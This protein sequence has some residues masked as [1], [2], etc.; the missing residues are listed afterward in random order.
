MNFLA[1]I[2][3]VISLIKIFFVSLLLVG[4]I[5]LWAGGID[6]I[7]LPGLGLVISLPF[8]IL[9]LLT[10]VIIL[11]AIIIFLRRYSANIRLQ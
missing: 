10:S 11:F 8:V 6:N 5:I 9:F 7:L 3:L 1:K 4:A 2:I